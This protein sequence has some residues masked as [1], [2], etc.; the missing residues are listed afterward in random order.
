MVRKSLL[1]FLAILLFGFTLRVFN[2]SKVPLYGDELTMVED[3]YS[4]LKTG[5]DQ[6]GAAWPLT[7]KMGAGRPAGY[8]YAS[9]PFVAVFGPTVWGVRGLSILSSLGIMLVI[10]L[11]AKKLFN[12]KVG[13]IAAFLVAV[14]PWDLSL[15]RGGFESHFAL[16]LALTGT[17]LFLEV[18]RHKLNFIWMTLIF[19]LAANTYPTYKLLLV[20]FPLVIVWYLDDIKKLIA[21][22]K[23][24]IIISTV[25]TIGIGLATMS[26]TFL[27]GSENRFLDINVFSSNKAMVEQDVNFNR[28]V[29]FGNTILGKIFYNKPLSYF[30]LLRDSYLKNFSLEYLVISGDGNPRHNMAT[31]GVIYVVEIITILLGLKYLTDQKDKRKDLILIVAWLLIAPLASILTMENHGLRT[32]FMLPPLIILSALGVWRLWNLKKPIIFWGIIVLWVAQFIPILQRTYFLAPNRFARFWSNIAKVV[33]LETYQ[34]K[35]NFDYVIVSSQ[36]DNVEYAYP[37]YNKIDPLDVMNADHCKTILGN[38]SFKKFG[39]VYI[40]SIPQEKLINF[41]GNLEGKIKYV[42]PITDANLFGKYDTLIDNDGVP[43]VISYIR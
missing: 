29:S 33:A 23:V 40:G 26:Q 13:L 14:S 7:F 19:G 8:V 18:K 16:F 17:Y 35:E 21:E 24:V 11:L 42:G 36:I 28:T 12:E 27:A 32:N 20:I 25:L 9:I 41:L 2:L 34:T 43:S 1:I 37:V 22:N 39:N 6:T 31:T 3:T 38:F 15:G 5:R 30:K 10:F 4:L